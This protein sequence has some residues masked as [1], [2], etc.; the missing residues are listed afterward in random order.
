MTDTYQIDIPACF[1]RDHFERDLPTG[2][3]VKQTKRLWTFVCTRDE[4]DEWRSDADYYSDCAGQGWDMGPGAIGM[5]S[6]A[7]ATVKRVDRLLTEIAQPRTGEAQKA[8]EAL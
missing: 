8:R 7:Q 6:S 1:A 5:Q 2:E 3:C 4:I